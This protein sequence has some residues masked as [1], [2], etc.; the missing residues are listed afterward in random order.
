MCGYMKEIPFQKPPVNGGNHRQ[1]TPGNI[2]A[3]RADVSFSRSSTGSSGGG[4]AGGG[5][6]SATKTAW[7]GV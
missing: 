5:G 4:W 1:S 3:F 2:T 7:K 6:G